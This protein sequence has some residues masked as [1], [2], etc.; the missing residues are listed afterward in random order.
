[1]ILNVILQVF[2]GLCRLN[3]EGAERVGVYVYVLSH[4]FIFLINYPTTNLYAKEYHIG[5]N[6]D[7]G[8]QSISPC[9]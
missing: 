2:T 9:T 8:G 7:L 5:D 4:K 3:G 1:V 6:N